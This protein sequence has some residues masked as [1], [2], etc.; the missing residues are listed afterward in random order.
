MRAHTRMVCEALVENPCWRAL[1]VA[2]RDAVFAAALLCNVAGSL[3]AVT[4][5]D[6]EISAPRS[7]RQ[8]SILA[9]GLLWR[10]GVS[11]EIREQVCGMIQW[12]QA[13]HDWIGQPDPLRALIWASQ[14]TRCDHVAMLCTAD[15][16]GRSSGDS[17]RLQERIARF[18]RLAKE[19][20]CLTQPWPFTSAHA[21]FLW[22]RDPQ[23][24]PRQAACDDTRGEVVMMSGLPG[25]GKDTWIA[26]NRPDHPVVSL[27]AIRAELSVHPSENQRRVIQLARAR[28]REHLRLGA[29]LVWNAT[30][31]TR[32][33]RE[34]LLRLLAD[35]SVTI[36]AVCIEAP[37][38]ILFAQNAAREASVPRTVIDRMVSHW[39]PPDTSEVHAIQ[40]VGGRKRS[41]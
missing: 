32:Q 21:R 15:V 24:D 17:A 39:Q 4:A 30:T 16:E 19:E 14:T 6:R 2:D 10:V 18:E 7:A 5:S 38:E 41:P 23:R 37:P 9:R 28:A 27:D 29:P 35:Y 31:L 13:P 34:P 26:A 36:Q 1:P 25:A 12:H 22:F 11:A 33:A 8:D 40:R 3:A 20:H